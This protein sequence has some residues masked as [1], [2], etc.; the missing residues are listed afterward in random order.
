MQGSAYSESSTC[1]FFL[2][3]LFALGMTVA[4]ILIVG[5]L[6]TV[7]RDDSKPMSFHLPFTYGCW[8]CVKD[9][10]IQCLVLWWRLTSKEQ[11][12]ITG[13]SAKCIAL[14]SSSTVSNHG[15][16][17]SAQKSILIGVSLVFRVTT[18]KS[19][20]SGAN[21]GLWW[22]MEGLTWEYNTSSLDKNTNRAFRWLF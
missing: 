12:P 19:S 3:S 18:S 20:K 10:S 7:M 13:G 17:L 16:C 15:P 4:D 21:W 5:L 9:V 2:W 14:S 6:D 8:L 1:V 22:D 11:E